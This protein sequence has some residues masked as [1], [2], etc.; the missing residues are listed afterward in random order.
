M[1]LLKKNLSSYKV[2]KFYKKDKYRYYRLCVPSH[3]GYFVAPSF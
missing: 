2:T 3:L 1:K